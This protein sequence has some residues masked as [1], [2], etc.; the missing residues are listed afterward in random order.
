MLLNKLSGDSKPKQP[1]V[2]QK[3]FPSRP[4]AILMTACS[5]LAAASAEN[6]T[7]KFFATLQQ[8]LITDGF[9]PQR[10]RQ[11][12]KSALFEDTDA[13]CSIANLKFYGWK[14]GIDRDKACTVVMHY[15]RSACYANAKLKIAGLLK[16]KS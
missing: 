1:M 13:I 15:N 4:P 10:I 11:P 6:D 2:P 8:H 7:F 12:H 14:P 5:S 16:E 9:S 3:M